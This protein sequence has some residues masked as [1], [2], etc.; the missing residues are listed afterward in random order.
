M[1]LSQTTNDYKMWDCFIKLQNYSH[2][3]ELQLWFYFTLLTTYLF[4]W[5]HLLISSFLL[6][7]SSLESA[8]KIHTFSVTQR[9]QRLVPH[10]Y[11]FVR[12]AIDQLMVNSFSSCF[13]FQINFESSVSF[14]YFWCWNDLVW[15]LNLF[16]NSVSNVQ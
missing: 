13:N 15:L 8:L 16:L 9:S 2:L 10:L 3:R 14:L 11:G 12:T 6:F 1:F 4:L 5:R 7:N